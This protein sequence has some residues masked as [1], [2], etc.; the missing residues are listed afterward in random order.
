MDHVNIN[1]LEFMENLPS[2]ENGEHSQIMNTITISS[3]EN[4]PC[5]NTFN[6]EHS[7]GDIHQNHDDISPISIENQQ[8][9]SSEVLFWYNTLYAIGSK[10]ID[11]F[12]TIDKNNSHIKSPITLRN[13]KRETINNTSDKGPDLHADSL[14]KIFYGYWLLHT[15]AI[16][17]ENQENNTRSA[18]SCGDNVNDNINCHSH[19]QR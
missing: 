7:P 6:I 5:S 11:A 14:T 13:R 9:Q 4:E 10:M 1:N 17:A 16:I 19:P 2:T 3:I 18:E 15:I 8:H 12:E